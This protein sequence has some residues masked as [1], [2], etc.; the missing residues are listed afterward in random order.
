M[1]QISPIVEMTNSNV[2]SEKQKPSPE[3]KGGLG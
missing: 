2:P 1:I 3:N